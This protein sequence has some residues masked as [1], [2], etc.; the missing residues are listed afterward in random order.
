MIEWEHVCTNPFTG[1][2]VWIVR[3]VEYVGGPRTWSVVAIRNRYS[4]KFLWLAAAEDLYRKID[5]KALTED[6]ARRGYEF[7]LAERKNGV[8]KKYSPAGV[9]V[10]NSKLV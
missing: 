8:I 3:Q 1:K 2:K 10:L 7:A 4:S 9:S 5:I 6:G